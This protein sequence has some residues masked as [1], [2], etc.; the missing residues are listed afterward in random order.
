MEDNNIGQFIAQ[1]RKDKS[2]TQKELAEKLHITDKA[3]SKWERGLSCPDI[4]LLPR[5]ADILEVTAGELLNG[6]REEAGFPQGAAQGEK[7]LGNVFV[8]AE[9][10]VKRETETLRL[11]MTAAFSLL[12]LLGAAVCAVCD[13]AIAG[14]FSW[15]LYPLASILFAW[16]VLTPLLRYGGRGMVWSLLS[17]S[18]FLIPFLYALDAILGGGLLFP[19]SFRVSLLSLAYLWCV[20]LLFKAPAIGK[21]KAG[22]FSLLLAIPLCLFMNIT[23]SAFIPE[24]FFDVWDALSFGIILA[25]AAAL[26]L[27]E[28]AAKRKGR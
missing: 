17:L 13:L 3:V 21:R 8:Y 24:P 14:A 19:I 25:A 7:A 2:M 4:A 16:L 9:K 12:L 26:L 20:Y 10:T 5:I 27:W 22:A 28:T 15:S 11:R 23:L 6:R 1:L 18:V